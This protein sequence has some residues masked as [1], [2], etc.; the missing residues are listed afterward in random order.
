MELILDRASSESAAGVSPNRGCRVGE[1]CTF[2][3]NADQESV[4]FRY[5]GFPRR[6]PNPI[7][8]RLRFCCGPAIE[9][10]T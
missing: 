6:D 4:I 7:S 8:K 5:L 3:V 9:V 1:V 10:S 2:K